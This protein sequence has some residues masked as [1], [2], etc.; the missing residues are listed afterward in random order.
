[1]QHKLSM[2]NLAAAADEDMNDGGESAAASSLGGESVGSTSP[3]GP[4]SHHVKTFSTI[5]KSSSASRHRRQDSAGPRWAVAPKKKSKFIAPKIAK[6]IAKHC[7]ATYESLDLDAIAASEKGQ[8]RDAALEDETEPLPQPPPV[9]AMD[10]IT[11][12]FLSASVQS[13]EGLKGILFHRLFEG[14]YLSDVISKMRRWLFNLAMIF[15]FR[16]SRAMNFTL[17]KK[18]S[19][20]IYVAQENEEPVLFSTQGPGSCFGEIALL[21]ERP[22]AATVRAATGQDECIVWALN[23]HDFH[24]IIQ[25]DS[26]DVQHE[27]V[28]FLKRI[29]LFRSNLGFK[30][31]VDLADSMESSKHSNGDV[32]DVI[33]PGGSKQ[34]QIV[35]SGKVRV[36]SFAPRATSGSF[37]AS[38]CRAM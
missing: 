24:S 28:G 7:S 22:R 2:K 18:G 34:F 12:E 9:D 1:M 15:L 23:R 4:T 19:F 20:D 5:S 26:L 21:Y 32:I 30:D 38:L 33:G 27:R 35:R 10:D 37:G 6:L 17:F 16:A 13:H 14:N 25:Q 36:V 11:R 29:D 8:D 3:P 31:L